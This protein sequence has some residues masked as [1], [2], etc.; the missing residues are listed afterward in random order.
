MDSVQ[1]QEL[2][3]FVLGILSLSPALNPFLISLFWGIFSFYVLYN[4]VQ[5]LFLLPP[6]LKTIMMAQKKIQMD[7]QPTTVLLLNS[8][9]TE[10]PPVK[11]N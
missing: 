3:L 4:L 9:G 10:R 6:T 7:E 2:N 1:T 11:G 8:V 5:Y